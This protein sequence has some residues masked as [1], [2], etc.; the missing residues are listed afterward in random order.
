MQHQIANWA[1][2]NYLKYQL[3]PRRQYRYPKSNV[4]S[5]VR[6]AVGAIGT[7]VAASL[8]FFFFK[9]KLKIN[10]VYSVWKRKTD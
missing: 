2:K 6:G 7:G 5:A 4:G 9:K 10:Y 3:G 1:L 8:V